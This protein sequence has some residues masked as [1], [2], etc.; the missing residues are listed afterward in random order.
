MELTHT[1]RELI[2]NLLDSKA[3]KLVLEVL[4]EQIDYVGEQLLKAENQFYEQRFLALWKALKFV[5]EVLRETPQSCDDMVRNDP[6]Q[7]R[8]AEELKTDYEA[9]QMALDFNRKQLAQEELHKQYNNIFGKKFEEE[10]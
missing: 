1:E 10:E 2:A 4:E 8:I 6:A 5:L 7:D 3:Y 9:L